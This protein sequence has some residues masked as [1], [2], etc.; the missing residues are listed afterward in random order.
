MRNKI[1]QDNKSASES[2]E[3]FQTHIGGS[4]LIEGVMMRGK[5]NWAVAVRTPS[6]EIHSEEHDLPL[7]DKNSW[8]AW[9]CVRGWFALIDSIKLSSKALDISAE[10]AF[11]EEEQEQENSS[12]TL[13]KAAEIAI[14][15]V[16]LIVALIVFNI[17]PSWL[18]NIIVGDYASSPFWWNT[19]QNVLQIIL[20]LLYV[21]AIARI[22]DIKRLFA[23]HG[24]EHK[25]IHCFEHGKDL[26]PENAQQFSRFHV[27][28]GTAFIV[29]TTILSILIFTV[30]P[31][32]ELLEL[33]GLENEN[34]RLALVIVMR[35]ALIPVVTGITYEFT[36]VWAG[37]RSNNPLVKA[38]IAPGLAMQA[39]TTSKPDEGMLECAIEAMNLVIAREK[40]HA[41]DEVELEVEQPEFSQ[42]EGAV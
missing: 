25:T 20:F 39:V 24:A 21:L 35:L 33:S 8:K 15:I 3:L 29:M 30:L 6:G 4:A 40:S 37:K 34:L 32:D 38:L 9:P 7:R 41:D 31:L 10:H 11:P 13:G 17:F 1:E 36:V 18:A 14:F 26:T 22:P 42:A 27:R 23:Y 19:V 16:A 5:Y 2:E 12:S 28:C